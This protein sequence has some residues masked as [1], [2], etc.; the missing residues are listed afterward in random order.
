[1]FPGAVFRATAIERPLVEA[2][3]LTFRKCPSSPTSPSTRKH[4]AQRIVGQRLQRVLV[5]SPFLLRTAVPPLQFAHGRRV[6][7]GCRI[8]KRLAI[9]LE[10]EL[11]PRAAP[12]DRGPSALVPA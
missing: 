6:R 7:E 1:M 12:H 5:Q 8:G 10:G 2:A 4:C 3:I 11:L 9:G